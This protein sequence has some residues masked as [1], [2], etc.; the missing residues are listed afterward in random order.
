MGRSQLLVLV[1][2]ISD[3]LLFYFVVVNCFPLSLRAEGVA[4]SSDRA[5]SEIASSLTLLAKTGKRARA[6]S[7]LQLRVIPYLEVSAIYLN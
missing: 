6:F 1:H 4:I 3:T 2:M 7:N 5:G